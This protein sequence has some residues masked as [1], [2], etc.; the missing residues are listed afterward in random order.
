VLRLI[1][2]PTLTLVFPTGGIADR[3]RVVER[4]VLRLEDAADPGTFEYPEPTVLPTCAL[5][6]FETLLP[7]LWITC[8]ALT[9]ARPCPVT[10]PSRA[11][12]FI[13]RIAVER[14]AESILVPR[15]RRRADLELLAGQSRP[16]WS[17]SLSRRPLE[18][19]CPKEHADQA[20]PPG[21]HGEP[22]IPIGGWPVASGP[23]PRPQ[24]P[25]ASMSE[26]AR[27]AVTSFATLPAPSIAS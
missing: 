3:S 2:L 5:L 13:L 21:G 6:R 11:C 20:P 18:F 26:R 27:E 8:P 25:V 4:A 10:L 7:W 22:T 9:W 14:R 12:S 23:A 19:D 15:C 16:L 17:C 1:D 24:A